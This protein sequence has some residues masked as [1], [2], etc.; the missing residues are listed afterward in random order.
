[1]QASNETDRDINNNMAAIAA[2]IGTFIRKD[3][4]DVERWHEKAEVIAL[5]SSLN[6]TNLLRMTLLDTRKEAQAWLLELARHNHEL[7]WKGFKR[8]A[9]GSFASRR[10]TFEA[11]SRFFATESCK[12]RNEYK[13]LLK[14]ADLL[15]TNGAVKTELLVKNVITKASGDIKAIRN[16]EA[17]RTVI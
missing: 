6:T 1:M 8:E 17:H 15:V 14:D 9:K 16:E 12:A 3:D 11:R 2:A 10:K 13:D 5:I 7:I 4:E